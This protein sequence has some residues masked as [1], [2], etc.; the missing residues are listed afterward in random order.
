MRYT[1]GYRMEKDHNMGPNNLYIITIHNC[2][3]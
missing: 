1:L 2:A 3:F